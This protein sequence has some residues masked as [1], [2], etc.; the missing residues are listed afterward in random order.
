MGRNLSRED[1]MRSAFLL[2]LRYLTF[3][4]IPTLPFHVHGED[5]EIFCA[6]NERGATKIA[7]I[8]GGIGGSFVTKFLSDYDTRSNSYAID[9]IELFEPSPILQSEDV[10]QTSSIVPSSGSLEE[11]WQGSR[12][13]SITLG[14]GTVVELGG[15]IVFDGNRLVLEI[16]EGDPNLS[17]SKPKDDGENK[18]RMP[19]GFGVFDGNGEMAFLVSDSSSIIRSIKVLW[20]YGLDVIRMSRAAQRALEPFYSIYDM[21]ESDDPNTYFK[22]ID[23]MWN[24][25]GAGFFDLSLM[26]F[27]DFLDTLGINR[28]TRWWRRF[29]PGQGNFRKELLTAMNLCN[30]NQ[31]NSQMNGFSGFTNYMSTTGQIFSIEGG[32]YHLIQ[33]AFRQA[34]AQYNRTSCMSSAGKE[35]IR[36]VQKKVTSVISGPK[37]ME[38]W[39]G[40]EELGKF[41]IVIV[42]APL[43]FSQISFLVKSHLDGDEAE[44]KPMFKVNDLPI[45]TASQYT[46][47][48]TTVVSNATLQAEYFGLTKENAPRSI[49]VTEKGRQLEGFTAVSRIGATDV[50]KVFSP[51]KLSTEKLKSFFGPYHTIEYIKVWGGDHGGA[52]PNYNGGGKSVMSTPYMLYDGK[53]EDKNSHGEEFPALY[54]I[55]SVEPTVACIELS[56]IGAKSVA[57]L[58]AQRLGL[59]A[60]SPSREANEEL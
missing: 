1:T 12:V 42:A 48:I 6:N 46:Q 47:V 17:R 18:E 50:Y 36:H 44:P 21:L 10:V 26:S 25:T 57:K 9:S 22:S 52:T 37:Q 35:I 13:A 2:L 40:K 16:M 34:Q 32:N 11:D 15:S 20:R 51:E 45:S 58:V 54:Y 7:V 27:D 43:Q 55:N 49:Y 60:S 14:D 56:A 33:S 3:F 4:I 23:E 24:A 30:N 8:G 5:Q 28:M 38:L 53:E 41:D 19:Q 59:V 29:L 39:S 31:P